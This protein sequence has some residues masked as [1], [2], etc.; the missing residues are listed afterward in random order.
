MHDLNGTK[1]S[2]GDLVLIPAEIISLG[3]SED[4]CNIGVETVFGR[5]PD[6]EKTIIYSINTGTVILHQKN[7]EVS[8]VKSNEE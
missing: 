3:E 2:V 8:N 6:G 4:Y 7:Y 1:L 5:R